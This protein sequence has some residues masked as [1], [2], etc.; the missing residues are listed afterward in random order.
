MTDVKSEHLTQLGHETKIP[1]SPDEAKLE[2]VARNDPDLR[3]AQLDL[4]GMLFPDGVQ[5]FDLTAALERVVGLEDRDAKVTFLK[6]GHELAVATV[7]RDHDSL[8]AELLMEQG[9][10]PPPSPPGVPSSMRYD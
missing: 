5:S 1:A 7:F 4:A 6:D 3:S 10:E 9:S 2:T 8:E